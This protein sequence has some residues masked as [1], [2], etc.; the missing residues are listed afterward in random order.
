[1][2]EKEKKNGEKGFIEETFPFEDEHNQQRGKNLCTPEG[3]LSK[4]DVF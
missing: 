3:I 1:M 4:E 2:T